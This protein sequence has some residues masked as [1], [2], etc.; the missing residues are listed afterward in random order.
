MNEP[1][2]VT[3]KGLELAYRL[4][5]DEPEGEILDTNAS[6]GAKKVTLAAKKT[7]KI[8]DGSKFIFKIQVNNELQKSEYPIFLTKSAQGLDSAG[9]NRGVVQRLDR[10]NSQGQPSPLGRAIRQ[11]LLGTCSQ[12]RC[13]YSYAREASPV[14]EDSIIA[15]SVVWYCYA[16]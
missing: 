11:S 1:L 7:V 4:E 14:A 6:I 8:A 2:T 10:R 12:P 15:E 5:A 3:L 16:Q 13:E 9:T